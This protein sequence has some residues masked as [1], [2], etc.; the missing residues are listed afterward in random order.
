[1]MQ[2]FRATCDG[3][4]AGAR[5]AKGDLVRLPLKEAV[6]EPVKPAAPAPQK[7]KRAAKAVAP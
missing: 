7:R 3:W 5:V 2:E 6:Y 1:M 4:V